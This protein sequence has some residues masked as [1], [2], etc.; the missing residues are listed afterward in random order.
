M[1]IIAIIQARLGST[2]LPGK[3]L[4]DLEGRTVLEHVIRRVKSSKLVTDVIVATTINKD[5]LEIVKLCA[6][7]GISVYCG[8]EDDVLD[9]YYQTARLFKADHIVRITSDCPLIDPMVIDEVITLHVREKADYTSNT[10]K[11]TYP[12]GEDI[13][14]FT[15]AALK[16]AWKK[17]NLSSEREHV[18]PFIRKNH[19]FKLVNLEYNKDLSHKR[20][21]LDNPEDFEFIKSIYKNICNKSPNFGM[22]EILEFIDKNPDIEKINQNINRNEGY[23]KSLKED[24]TLNL[25]YIDEH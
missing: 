12:D 5:D 20:W 24:K 8:S 6:N 21:T 3:V 2:R 13:E 17:A 23:L 11:E 1:K 15:F 4:L 18:T 9:R 10:L 16:E 19:A 25:K 14:V 7:L 22:M